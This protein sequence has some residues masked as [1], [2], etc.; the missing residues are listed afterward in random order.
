MGE[1]SH[2]AADRLF[3]ELRS[4][5]EGTVFDGRKKFFLFV[6][7]GPFD[8][9]PGGDLSLRRQFLNWSERELPDFI[10]LLA[11]EAFRQTRSYRIHRVINLAKF[12]DFIATVA[13]AVVIFPESPGSWSEVGFF[14]NSRGIPEKTILANDANF[15]GEPSFLNI[16][17]FRTI[18]AKSIFSPRIDVR[19]VDPLNDFAVIK[20]KLDVW[21]RDEK[22]R[23]FMYAPYKNLDLKQR[24]LVVLEMLHLL[25]LVTFE[26][27]RY[28]VKETFGPASL[29]SV[30][31]MLS[32]LDGAKYVTE[33]NGRY[34]LA[35][36]RQ[37]MLEF[38]IATKKDELISHVTEYY[39]TSRP[40]LY[41][42]IT[43][44]ASS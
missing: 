41:D 1:F 40:E 29:D 36:G 8:P 43:A 18:D 17:P 10:V 26:D 34:A 13:D 28:A 22:R 4:A 20:R 25:R 9:A 39:Q 42:A 11:E 38:G 24:L 5:F 33:V 16:G 7:G 23:R 30:G 21:K 14:S 35:K 32:I 37:T 44:W 19:T 3:V 2:P 31:R 15:R 12:E 6:C 27:L